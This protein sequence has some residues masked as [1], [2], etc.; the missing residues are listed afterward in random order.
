MT[1]SEFEIDFSR[2]DGLMALGTADFHD[3]LRNS[4]HE[5][6]RGEMPAHFGIREEWFTEYYVANRRSN[7]YFPIPPTERLFPEPPA[8]FDGGAGLAFG[9]GFDGAGFE[10]FDDLGDGVGEDDAVDVAAVDR[11]SPQQSILHEIKQRLPE[12][13]ADEDDGEVLDLVGLNQSD[14]L[15]SL[16]EGPETAG[17]D[18]EG[19]GVFDQHDFADE[20]VAEEDHAVEV[21]VGVLLVGEDD[22]AADGV[23]SGFFA[24]SVGGFHDAW[25]AAGHDVVTGAGDGSTDFT[26]KLI[27]GMFLGEAGGAEDG[28]G[29]ADEVKLSKSGNELRHDAEETEELTGSGAGAFQK[30]PVVQYE[31]SLQTPVRRLCRRL[32]SRIGN[33][34]LRRGNLRLGRGNGFAHD[35]R[36]SATRIR[37]LLIDRRQT[38]LRQ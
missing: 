2:R 33:L 3:V 22:V 9:G 20:E 12:A 23:A 32:M 36:I 26:G 5:I 10:G 29:G 18:D 31:L 8:A 30:S 24:A 15:E 27:V 28:D 11:A 7:E 16:V 21:G 25:S 13:A 1:N 34:N 35:N 19:L 17:H 37:E 6:F 38:R 4:G 14:G